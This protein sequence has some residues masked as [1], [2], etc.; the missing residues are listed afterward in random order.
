M[1]KLIIA[2]IGFIFVMCMNCPTALMER[3]DIMVDLTELEDYIYNHVVPIASSWNDQD[4]YAVSFFVYANG[5]YIYKGK[6][7]VTELSIG[8]VTEQ[9]CEH[10]PLLSE[11]RWN[12]PPIMHNI[13]IFQPNNI[14]PT[15][16]VLVD[17]GMAFLFDWYARNGIK[18][19][20]QES[21]ETQYDEHMNYIG[22]GPVGYWE[23]LTAASRVA[24]RLQEEGFIQNAFGKP[25][26]IIVHEYE[27]YGLIREATEYANP[28][29]EAAEFLK[30]YDISVEEANEILSQYLQQRERKGN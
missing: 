14:S 17:D 4:A 1:S 8:Y 23:V 9:D 13:P 3:N 11:D 27:I 28:H 18:A 21:N 12:L 10:A 29:G 20:G 22:K 2:L 19:I 30:Y 16:P 26:P 15:V 7:N 25:L 5:A 24:R 6:E